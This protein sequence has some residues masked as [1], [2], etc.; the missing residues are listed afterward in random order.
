MMKS[1]NR[2]H[3]G[4]HRTIRAV[5]LVVAMM[6]T[7]LW[8]ITS[9]AI[10]RAQAAWEG[11]GNGT[12]DFGG[13]LTS[14]DTLGF[15][16]S[17][18]KFLVSDGFVSDPGTTSLWS[19]NQ[20]EENTTGTFVLKAEGKTVNKY[21]TFKD[22]GISH[23]DNGDGTGR[24]LTQLNV[25]LKDR[26]NQIIATLS[27][28]GN[29]RINDSVSQ[30]STL[31][32][33]ETSY[34]YENV[35]T[36]ELTW[37]YADTVAP[38]NLNLENIT[39][40]NISA[41]YGV[42]YDGNGQTS[43][44]V[45]TASS[46]EFAGT[47]ITLADKGTL[48]RDGYTF[49]GWNT[50]ADGTGTTYPA[51]ST[52]TIGSSDVTL[53]AKWEPNRY[54]V[55]YNG[56][57]HQTGTVP[58]DSGTYLTGQTV[59]AA[60]QGTL[61]KSGYVFTG[62]NTAVNGTGTSYA[63]GQTF[64]MGSANVT[65]Y[66]Q[67]KLITYTLN[68]DGNT[69]DSGT[70]PTGGTYAPG[71]QATVAPQGNL[72]KAGY[73][74]KVWNTKADGTGD[75][76]AVG[77]TLTMGSANVTLYAQ[78]ELIT[79]T[80]NY[81]GNTSDSGT[82]PTGG[83]YAPNAPVTVAP[84]GN[85]EK[86]GY[87]FESWNT[88]ADGTGDAY[89]AG[90][91]LTM[92]S[93]NVTLYAQWEL[94]K[95][96]LNYDGNTSDSGTVPTGGTYAPN[97]PVTVAP[98]G[99]L[100]KAGYS[101]EGWNT[102]A[103]GTGDAYAA[104]STLTMGSANVT[105]Y[106]QWELITYTLNYEGNTSDSGTVPTGGTY[107][108]NAPVTVAPQ[109]S[110]EK[111]GYSFEGWNTKADG[112]GDA[113][114]AGSTL[115]MGS[116]NVTLY[117]QWE[118]I[119]YTLNYD[120]NNSDSGTVPTGGTYAP[121]APVTVAPQGSLEKA[122]YS[123]ESWNTKA[124]GTGDAYAAGSTL[125]MGSA[126]VTLYA[127]WELIT[128]TLNYDGNND[129]SGTVPTGGTYAPNAPVTVA[130]QG[131]LEKAGYS[132]EGWNTKADGT[133]DA[134]AAGS[135]LT[136]GSANVTL[137]A[138]WELITYTLNYEGNTSDSGTVPTGGTYA[139]N[140]Q[141]TVAP[142]GTLEKAGYSFEGWNTKADGTGDAY[143]VGSILTMGSANVTL[144]AQWELI[145]Y[146]LNY[147]GNNSDSGTVPT[148]GTYAP[149]APVTVAPQGSLEKAGYSFEGW[150]TKADG[151]GDAY[152]AGSILTMGSAN[153]TLYAQWELI[154]YT[155]NY[156]GNTSDS[157]TVPTGGTYAPNA[158]VTVAP[159]G[160][161]EKAGY[162]FEGWN[163]K[164]D[165][166]GTAYA[167]GATLIMGSA[168][169]TL[170]AQ[171]ELITYWISYDGNGNDG[172][173]VPS[174]KNYAPGTQA[175]LA[176]AGNMTKS[177]STFI[178]WN[179]K[180]DG[181]GTAYAAGST[182]TIGTSNVT[183]YAVW[184]LLPEAKYYIT[185]QGNGITS[186]VAPT[187]SQG[188]TAGAS[189]TVLGSGN[190]VKKGNT[191][192]GWNT[193][194]D[195]TGTAYAAGST[196]TIGTSNVTLYAVWTLLPE[197]KYY[198]TYQGNGI[199]SG[200]APT[201]SQGYT[202][203]ASVTVLGSG[204]MV[205]KGNTFTG[206]N[207]KADGTGTAYAAGST[208]TIGTSN[209]T[210]YAI[211][212][213]LPEAKYYITY[214]GNGITSGVAPTDSQGYTAGASATVLGSG[215]MVK[216]GNTFTGWNT[217][218]DGTGTAYAAGSTLTIGTSNVTL[219]AIWALLPEAKYY[220]TYQGN[221][222]TSG[223]APTDSQGYTAGASATVLGS[224]NMVK[225]GYTFA[226]W[227]SKSDGTG[228]IYL[229]GHP[230]IVLSNA[231]LYAQWTAIPVTAS[232]ITYSGNGQTSGEAP[233]DNH[234]YPEGTVAQVADSGTLQR[235]GYTFEGWNTK[236]DGTG[237]SFLAGSTIT[238]GSDKIILYAIWLKVPEITYS[239]TYE[240]NGHTS[241]EAPSDNISYPGGSTVTIQDG[242]TLVK[243]GYTF[244]GW[245][246]KADGTGTA[247]VQG[248]TLP[249]S[250]DL[251]LYAQWTL[252]PAA[253][254]TVA[255]LGNGHTSGNIPVDSNTYE[256]GTSVTLAGIGTMRKSGYSF[257]GWNTK[258]DGTGT[259]YAAGST[260]TVGTENIILYA[261]WIVTS[262]PGTPGTTPD[263][264]PETTDNSI[265]SGNVIGDSEDLI[266]KV[267][268]SNQNQTIDVQLNEDKVAQ[269]L[270]E[271][272]KQSQLSLA[273]AADPEQFAVKLSGKM[274]VKI[275]EREATLEI[276]TESAAYTV[277][278]TL[279]NLN[280]AADQL[281]ASVE[282]MQISIEIKK[283][284]A[285]QQSGFSEAA[286]QSGAQLIIQPIEF[287]ITVT[288]GNR[289]IQLNKFTGYV[290]REILLPEGIDPSKIT[291]GAVLDKDGKII[292]HVPT[293]VAVQNGQYSAHINSLTNSM[294]SIIWNPVTFA[295]VEKHWSKQ[296]VN[297]MG[298]RLVVKGTSEDRFNP[299]GS[300]TRAE[301]AAILVRA[302]G[303][304]E[305][306]SSSSFSDV[307]KNDWYYQAVG[308]AAEYGIVTGYTDGSFKPG[309]TL[310]RQEAMV[311]IARAM[312]ITASHPALSDSAKAAALVSFNDRS[313]VA[314]W[315]EQSV[316]ETVY[317]GLAKGSPDGNLNPEATMTRAETAVMVRRLLQQAGLINK[318]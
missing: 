179:T 160:S 197:A 48:I 166:T 158:P 254:Y 105:L 96:T 204:N 97:A 90:S 162:S 118:L 67:W 35:T 227:N 104:G 285:Q 286:E 154:T 313:L 305:S 156:D 58:S 318:S 268:T 62:W 295:D 199:T 145:T 251:I 75:A 147:D 24:I 190:M 302:L 92:G 144:Y 115:T 278:A 282:D 61:A 138:Q 219:Y 180:A 137:Y 185:Y 214:Q 50:K 1:S 47:S 106:A 203:G 29:V 120:G 22:F 122:G 235:S 275:H 221:S 133:G 269:K 20:Q 37:K 143:A 184:T 43:G 276:R 270:D 59:T 206:W 236:A 11:T 208:L 267:N 32:G 173:A 207:T 136:M 253:T 87:S 310:S 301:F 159:Q 18:D 210:L 7:T 226:G 215:N 57:G 279:L 307:S 52:Y 151:T 72:V 300:V 17:G 211:W 242:G 237:T 98:Q 148:G 297:D 94:I 303:L 131:S 165:G 139:P 134:Y 178:G 41:G 2:T 121:N 56:N 73:S 229:E 78:W 259:A 224:G 83:T 129:D 150:N 146:T 262:N 163:T 231:T 126:N 38:S 66:A 142:Q 290:E 230:I 77:S 198:I 117:A 258:A 71:A 280:Q 245:N 298:S 114:A 55:S 240:G 241:G 4:A 44:T 272:G 239:I 311:M 39:V 85:L 264:K 157:G 123:F 304:Q 284:S 222:I 309:A 164:A 95:Y 124:D 175:T 170:Y 69:S 119:T 100:E 16:K 110:L 130:P 212:T 15:Q 283:T 46:K 291:T 19:E 171:W 249:M 74:F 233:V 36:L 8:G 213:L 244:A 79:Y 21:F 33:S 152:A 54:S 68:Y 308:K 194:A 266:D 28:S 189:A 223:V 306:G 294:Y 317:S 161:L 12:Y 289:S 103:D 315:A 84:Q 6:A 64:T 112:T 13:P 201:D 188:Y 181:T 314:A 174:G 234:M 287:T 86:T 116:A 216:K 220:I 200:V 135:T 167:A 186:G 89:A 132:F 127:Q 40:A 252:V 256:S 26:N 34:T 225:N 51:N 14:S 88:K 271:E 177:G 261:K 91:S 273:V 23:V 192:S 183:L 3:E 293:F 63:S 274:L 172:G 70:V 108:P 9:V 193:K 187:D 296:D 128:Y 10:D 141:V 109:G 255:Y 81:D 30:L 149:N 281:G 238:V 243:T 65:L 217:K 246:T 292:Y 45:P 248:A 76:Y 140:A 191:F 247:Y 250:G 42:V 257:S 299:E 125:T 5:M 93:A 153:V 113:Y 53:Y 316:A 209:V 60:L 265:V 196:L 202:A 260:I 27:N 155:L 49:T 182:L 176:T 288:S 169:I 31:L 101:F 232:S 263:T 107:A 195:G 25:V 277:P 99:S 205:K 82:V 80:L 312:R 102:K 168:N 228:T 111:A 218:A